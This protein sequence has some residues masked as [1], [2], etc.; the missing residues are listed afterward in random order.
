[1]SALCF[2][3][4]ELRISLKCASR[5]YYTACADSSSESYQSYEAENF[6]RAQQIVDMAKQTFGGDLERPIRGIPRPTDH[7]NLSVFC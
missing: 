3:R 1:M 7:V 5:R 4:H 2:T 6:V